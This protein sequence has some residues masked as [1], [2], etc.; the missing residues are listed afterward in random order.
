MRAQSET[1]NDTPRFDG[2]GSPNPTRVERLKLMRQ[3][4]QILFADLQPPLVQTCRS[5]APE[6]LCKGAHILA[7][8]ARIVDVPMTFSV[9]PVDGKP[10]SLIPELRPYAGD[11]NVFQRMSTA[12][13]MDPG[14]VAALERHGRKTLVISGFTSEAAV[15][16]SV[17]GAIEA[18]YTVHVPVDAIGSWWART[19]EAALRQ[20]EIA[21]AI[22]TSVSTLATLLAPDSSSENGVQVL[23]AIKDLDAGD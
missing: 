3:D 4:V 13:F 12:T 1:D 2:S 11:N 9:V 5:I 19:E 22:P 20:M 8:V 6:T 15:L 23:A 14:L 17:V 7:R 10:G 21:G 16:H 18:G